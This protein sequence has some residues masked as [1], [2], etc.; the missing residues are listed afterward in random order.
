MFYRVNC[1][2]DFT[3]LFISI[4]INNTFYLLYFSYQEI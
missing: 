4:L 1:Y 3:F 2:A